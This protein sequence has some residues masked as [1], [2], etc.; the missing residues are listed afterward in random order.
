MIR[1]SRQQAAGEEDMRHAGAAAI[2]ATIVIA[3]I[4]TAVAATPAEALEPRRGGTLV[5]PVVLGEPPNYDCHAGASTSVLFRLAPSY[6]TLIRISQSDYPKIVPDLAESWTVA[7]DGLTYTFKIRSNV[8][9]H[10]GSTLSSADVK[11]SLDRIRQPPPG[12]VSARQSLYKT[13]AAVDA[14]DADTV[15]VR[16]SHPDAAMLIALAS[17]WNCIYSAAKLAQD[18]KFPERNVLGTGPFK[19]VEHI[20]G[21]EWKAERFDAYFVK[22]KPY[23]DGFRA[24]NISP[25]ALAAGLSAGQY[26]I[27]FTGVTYNERELVSAARGAKMTWGESDATS[28]LQLAFNTA[29]PP[30]NDE[31]VRRAFNLAI[32]RTAGEKV[33]RNQNAIHRAGGYLRNGSEFAPK[34]DELAQMEGFGPDMSARRA[35]AKKLLAEAGATD[36]HLTFLNR[37]NYSAMGVFLI[38]QWRQIGATVTQDLPEN[39][40]YFARNRAGQFDLTLNSTIN[41]V[42]DPTMQ[43]AYLQSYSRAPLNVSRSEDEKVDALYDAQA[44]ALDPRERRA[45]V[46]K[47]HKYLLTKAYTVP[48]FWAYRQVP[49]AAEVHGYTVSPNWYV[50]QDIADVWLAP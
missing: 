16:L 19:F 11:A 5:F 22:G 24:I 1:Q 31:R 12:V 34:P 43:M 32:D 36:L 37:P 33:L 2:T 6:S 35:E 14:P 40:A 46:I 26:Q 23:L 8:K 30:F 47:L 45:L 39:A 21:S 18:P 9:F 7:P 13:I 10:D 49:M 50:G 17:P 20:A 48:L 41:F 15:I 42:D 38:D 29:K 4:V 3:S 28:T 27:E 25:A 44:M